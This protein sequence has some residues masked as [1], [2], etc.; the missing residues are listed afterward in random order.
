MK[1]NFV[2]S[3]LNS[4]GGA[5]MLTIVTMKAI[6]EM[7][8]DIELT[9]LEKP[10]ITKIE[11]AFGKNLSSALRK[12]KKINMIQMFDERSITDNIG[13]GYELIINTHAD[14]IPYFSKELSKDN[15]IT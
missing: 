15:T 10:D 2:F 5:E 4:C 6:L 7:G 8:F 14:I 12:I 1:V 9:T 13:N 3:D 11:K